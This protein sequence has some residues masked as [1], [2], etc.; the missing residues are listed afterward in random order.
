MSEEEGDPEDDE[1]PSDY[2]DVI[3]I[4]ASIAALSDGEEEGED[5]TRKENNDER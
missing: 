3:D 2:D 5:D 4:K 1:D